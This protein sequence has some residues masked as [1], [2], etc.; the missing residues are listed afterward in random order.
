MKWGFGI[1][2]TAMAAIVWRQDYPVVAGMAAIASLI[3]LI[4]WLWNK[5]DSIIDASDNASKWRAA[6]RFSQC[7]II[8][9]IIIGWGG[10]L[11]NNGDISNSTTASGFLLGFGWLIIQLA[12]G[13]KAHSEAK[14]EQAAKAQKAERPIYYPKSM[15]PQTPAPAQKIITP[16][17][18]ATQE[19]ALLT[20]P[21]KGV[22]AHEDEIFEELMEFNPEYDMTKAELAKEYGHEV[23]VYKW[24]PKTTRA[25]LIPEPDNAYDPNAVKIV[26][27][28]VTVGYIPKERCEAVRNI[29]SEQRLIDAYCVISGSVFKRLVED[30]YDPLKDKVIYKLESGRESLSAIINIR[31]RPVQTQA[32][33]N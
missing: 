19:T 20:Y 26:V 11:L 1:F 31:V 6:E 7:L 17:R 2:F 25:E 8:L 12:I 16:Q 14:K 33:S 32:V 5:V 9:P 24:T 15:E 27:S 23:T 10:Y 22:F 3:L 13:V 28:G 30:D 4:C 18:P 21:V 29:L